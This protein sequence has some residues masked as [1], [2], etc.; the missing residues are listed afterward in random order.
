MYK[1]Q[2]KPD[3]LQNYYCGDL[4][5]ERFTSYMGLVRGSGGE[6]REGEREGEMEGGREGEENN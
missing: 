4:A 1:G 2:L 6:G 5:D 3:Q